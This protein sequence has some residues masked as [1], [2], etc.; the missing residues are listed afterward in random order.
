MRFI[1]KRLRIESFDYSQLYYVYFATLCARHQ[2][3]VFSNS[4]LASEV[5]NAIHWARANGRW[6]VYCFCLMPDHLHLALSPGECN[7]NLSDTIG[8]FK[9]WTTRKAWDMGLHGP[10]WQRSW[11]DH[12]ARHEEDLTRICEYICN[13]PVRSGLVEEVSQWP[14]S[15]MPDPLPL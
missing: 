1:R 5:V 4:A 2:T 11:Y 3:N 14:Y 8:A 13:N 9:K 10:L 15:G 12:V 7:G 6:E